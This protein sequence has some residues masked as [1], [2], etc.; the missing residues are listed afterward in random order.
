MDGARE[1]DCTVGGVSSKQRER[2]YASLYQTPISS[3]SPRLSSATEREARP[4]RRRRLHVPRM[5]IRP[6]RDSLAGTLDRLPLEPAR[7]TLG[8]LRLTRYVRFR[9][10][11]SRT[12]SRLSRRPT[13]VGRGSV[14]RPARICPDRGTGKEAFGPRLRERFRERVAK[15]GGRP[16]QE[17]SSEPRVTAHRRTTIPSTRAAEYTTHGRTST[18]SPFFAASRIQRSTR[19]LGITTSRRP[20]AASASRVNAW[21]ST[22]RSLETPWDA[23][24]QAVRPARWTAR[25][26]GGTMDRRFDAVARFVGS[27]GR[28]LTAG[29]RG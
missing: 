11:R 19:R 8:S 23:A 10:S 4:H 9:P 28:R 29:R 5:S 20:N 1:N 24:G 18:S 3:P 2:A 12:G 6:F 21:R 15:T 14:I 22:S 27:G 25:A 13:R 26:P 16:G 17:P 7:D